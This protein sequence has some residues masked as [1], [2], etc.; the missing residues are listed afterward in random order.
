MRGSLAIATLN[1]SISNV[2]DCHTSYLKLLK[3]RPCKNDFKP[4]VRFA[5]QAQ[6]T[7]H[8]EFQHGEQPTLAEL[9]T[10]HLQSFQIL[11]LA[12]IALICGSLF[13]DKILRVADQLAE[14]AV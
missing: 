4:A 5:F 3:L 8:P 2:Y 10:T 12:A 6:D 13:I 11:C 14:S 7:K 1:R 9:S